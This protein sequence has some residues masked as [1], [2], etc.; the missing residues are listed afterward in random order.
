MRSKK[1]VVVVQVEELHQMGAALSMPV[2]YVS[3]LV[4]AGFI[5]YDEKHN[6]PYVAE[7][8]GADPRGCGDELNMLLQ[9]P[10]AAILPRCPIKYAGGW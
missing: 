2:H 5:T 3:R 7:R 1:T 9:V 4:A 10:G 6:P 8:M